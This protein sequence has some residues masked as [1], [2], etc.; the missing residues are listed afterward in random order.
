MFGTNLNKKTMY[1]LDAKDKN[2]KTAV[3]FIKTCKGYDKLVVYHIGQNLKA[4]FDAH[5]NKINER[6]L[7]NFV[8][9]FC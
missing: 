2:Y 3:L 5:F 8:F 9:F 6:V 1:G 7:K 4:Y